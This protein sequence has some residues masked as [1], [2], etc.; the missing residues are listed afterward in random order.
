MPTVAEILDG[1]VLLEVECID[2]LYLNA[3]VPKL[4]LPG[5]LIRFLIEHRKYPIPSLWLWRDSK[6]GP[7]RYRLIDRKT[8]MQLLGISDSDQLSLSHRS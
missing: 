7:D 6:R 2:R 4:Q 8:L 3:Y 1:H 5:D